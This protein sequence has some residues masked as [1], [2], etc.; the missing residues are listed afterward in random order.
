MYGYNRHRVCGEQKYCSGFLARPGPSRRTARVSGCARGCCPRVFA[1]A[2]PGRDA[3]GTGFDCARPRRAWVRRGLSPGA[4]AGARTEP[5]G[6]SVAGGGIASWSGRNPSCGLR[7]DR[8]V[9]LVRCA[10]GGLSAPRPA[11]VTP[12]TALLGRGQARTLQSRVE[13]A[14]LHRGDVGV[15]AHAEPESGQRSNGALGRLRDLVV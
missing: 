15:S 10:R 13:R 8:L 14:A 6:G 9:R 4:R 11:V 5:D 7:Y 3:C 12:E 2:S 1:R